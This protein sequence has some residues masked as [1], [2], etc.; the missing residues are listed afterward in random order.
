VTSADVERVAEA[1]G[2]RFALAV[3]DA[4]H[5]LDVEDVVRGQRLTALPS[6]LSRQPLGRSDLADYNVLAI[7]KRKPEDSLG[8]ARSHAD[9]PTTTLLQR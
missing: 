4:A 6:V 3:E 7:D 8:I 1:L 2:L 5:R 9:D